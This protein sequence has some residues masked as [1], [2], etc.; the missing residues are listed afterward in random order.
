MPAQAVSQERRELRQRE[1][2]IYTLADDPAESVV[3]DDV[4]V[5][6]AEFVCEFMVCGREL[7]GVS[8]GGLGGGGQR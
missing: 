3:A 2:E 5:F 6:S 4:D 8:A 7:R 1:R